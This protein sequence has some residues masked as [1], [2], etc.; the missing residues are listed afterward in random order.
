M[1]EKFSRVLNMFLNILTRS[2]QVNTG[3]P[4]DIK[5]RSVQ[6]KKSKSKVYKKRKKESKSSFKSMAKL[7]YIATF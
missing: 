2:S 3:V 6:G 4:N 5:Q 1:I 7:Q